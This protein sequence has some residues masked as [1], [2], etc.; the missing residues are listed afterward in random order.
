MNTHDALARTLRSMSTATV[1]AVSDPS[2][3]TS[4]CCSSADKSASCPPAA[5]PPPGLDE[6]EDDDDD[7]LATVSKNWMNK[8]PVS[9]NMQCCSCSG[10]E[11]MS[12]VQA[13]AV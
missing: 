7:D 6:D 9:M 3:P 13:H 11:R 5:A 2:S 10:V 4:K 12:C 1:R 8:K